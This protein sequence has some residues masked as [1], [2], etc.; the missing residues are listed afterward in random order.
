MMTANEL[1]D[2]AVSGAPVRYMSIYGDMIGRIERIWM[3]WADGAWRYGADV[4]EDRATPCVIRCDAESLEIAAK[5][6]PPSPE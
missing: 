2:A 3:R 4:I 1:K 5:R 6:K